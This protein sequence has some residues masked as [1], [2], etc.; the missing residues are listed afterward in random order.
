MVTYKQTHVVM[1]IWLGMLL[2]YVLSDERSAK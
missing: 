1:E 2:F